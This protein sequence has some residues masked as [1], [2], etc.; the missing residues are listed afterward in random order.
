MSDNIQAQLFAKDFSQTAIFNIIKK[1]AAY[2]NGLLS[3]EQ[4]SMF[5]EAEGIFE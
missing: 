3:Q 4:R 5:K 1:H 2:F